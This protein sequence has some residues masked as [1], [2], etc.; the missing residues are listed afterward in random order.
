MPRRA[1]VERLESQLRGDLAT[2]LETLPALLVPSRRSDAADV[3]FQTLRVALPSL[4][5]RLRHGRRRGRRR[6]RRAQ[7]V[8]QRVPALRGGGGPTRPGLVVT[9]CP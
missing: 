3:S 4:A 2:L 1:L 5:L 6:A 9:L 8:A 7:R